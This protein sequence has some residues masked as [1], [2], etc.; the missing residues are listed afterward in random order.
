MRFKNQSW[1]IEQH[2]NHFK[3]I[4]DN[5]SFKVKIFFDD[6]IVLS[7][8]EAISYVKDKLDFVNHNQHVSSLNDNLHVVTFLTSRELDRY[9][10]NISFIVTNK[11]KRRPIHYTACCNKADLEFIVRGQ[12]D[13]FKNVSDIKITDANGFFVHLDNEVL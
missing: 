4:T 11:N 12:T 2:D 13:K 1:L 10:Y 7:M 6:D 9:M 5:D 8:L 3:I